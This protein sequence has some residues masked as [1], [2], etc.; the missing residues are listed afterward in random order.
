MSVVVYVHTITE[1]FLAKGLHHGH[2]ATHSC[3]CLHTVTAN[4]YKAEIAHV[5]MRLRI[6]HAP[7]T[8]LHEFT[9]AVL[10]TYYSLHRE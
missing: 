5:V 7:P 9:L 8:M 6:E 4:L 3:L 10:H 2:M 1:V